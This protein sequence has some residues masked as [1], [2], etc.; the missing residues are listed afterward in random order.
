[1]SETKREL[2]WKVATEYEADL[3]LDGDEGELEEEEVEPAS[4]DDVAMILLLFFMVASLAINFITEVRSPEDEKRA[5]P[6]VNAGGLPIPP[7]DGVEYRVFVKSDDLGRIFCEKQT[8]GTDAKVL[9]TSDNF[10]PGDEISPEEIEHF[11][12]AL[13]GMMADIPAA[14]SD[15]GPFPVDVVVFVS[16]DM[17]YGKTQEVWYA[18]NDLARK[19]EVFLSRVARI[20]WRAEILDN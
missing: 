5:V 4:F 1:M 12:L 7:P 18:L 16:H 9:A 3:L 10:F 19:N 8:V 17:A 13:E 6:V 14:T 2:A 11:Q 20:A 15:D